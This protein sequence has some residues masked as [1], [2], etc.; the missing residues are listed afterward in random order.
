MMEDSTNIVKNID[1]RTQTLY[2][3]L[4]QLITNKLKLDHGEKHADAVSSIRR[5]RILKDGDFLVHLRSYTCGSP[6]DTNVRYYPAKVV[7][8]EI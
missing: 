3:L 8:S 2:D 7:I 1:D 4:E 6:H 5:N